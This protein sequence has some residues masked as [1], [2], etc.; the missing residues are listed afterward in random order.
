[1]EP[2]SLLTATILGVILC[3]LLS[4]FLPNPPSFYVNQTGTTQTS[5]VSHGSVSTGQ[6]STTTRFDFEHPSLTS[7]PYSHPCRHSGTSVPE[8]NPTGSQDSQDPYSL[9]ETRVPPSLGTRS[10][11]I[12]KVGIYTGLHRGRRESGSPTTS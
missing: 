4:F 1:M 7:F 2:V 12:R 8:G 6:L 5:R 9:S 11:E 10:P 3:I